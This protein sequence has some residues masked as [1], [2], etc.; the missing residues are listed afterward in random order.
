M[1][2]VRTRS[3]KS[4]YIRDR[5]FIVYEEMARD[6]GCSIDYLV[7]EAMRSY[8]RQRNVSVIGGEQSNTGDF[9]EVPMPNRPN[10]SE[11]VPL[12]LWFNGQRHIIDIPRFIIGRGGQN[13]RCDLVIPD[14][15]ISR[16]HC[17]IVYSN[18]EH[19]IQDLNSTNGV[20]FNQEK[21]GKKR[22]EEG[23]SFYLCDYPISFTYRLDRTL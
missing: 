12:F 3:L 13:K 14:N 22:I 6:L 2:D 8:A 1:S 7:N 21:V 5:L 23:E 20:E 11:I 17:A 10:D 16:Q 15:N 19:Y 9:S 4:L 18:G